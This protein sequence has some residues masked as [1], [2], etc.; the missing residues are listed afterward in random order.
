MKKKRG[1]GLLKVLLILG[2][3]ISL[4]LIYEHFS[5]TASK[6]CTFGNNFDCG[7]VNKGPYANIDG[8]SYMVT[9]DYGLPIPLLDIADQHVI[10]DILTS[11]A[12]LGFLTL[13]FVFGLVIALGKKKGFLWVKKEKVLSWIRGVLLFGVIYGLYLIFVMH[14]LLKTY[15]IV[16]LGLDIVLWISCI[17]VWRMKA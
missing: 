14:S 2:M 15:C 11:N 13:L 10:L 3:L 6:Y 8:L 17:I 5:A 12:F 4:F 16:C 9:I 7:I 1:L